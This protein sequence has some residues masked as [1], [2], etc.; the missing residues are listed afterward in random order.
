MKQ[1][2]TKQT[3]ETRLAS[4]GFS[5]IEVLISTLLTGLVLVGAMHCVGQVLESREVTADAV[6]ADALAHQLMAEVLN[7]DYAEPDSG[8]TFGPESGESTGNR[9]RFDD[10]DDYHN[11]QAS[12]P[13][14]RDG[15]AL[16][17]LT[18]WERRVTVEYVAANDLLDVLSDDDGVKRI[19]VTVLKDG[20]VLSKLISLRTK[21]AVQR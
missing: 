5:L 12:P 19:T 7:S 2:Q 11:W 1:Q 17:G 13:E 21:E 18:G 16:P 20:A 6:R 10:V 3:S 9:A 15:T 4:R 8:A 14:S